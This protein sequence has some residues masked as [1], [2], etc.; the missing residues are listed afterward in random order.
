VIGMKHFLLVFD[1]SQGKLCSLTEF[2][3]R[4]EA[5]QAR[6]DTEKLHRGQPSI[7]VVVLTAHSKAD[8]RHTHARYFEDVRQMASQ[9]LDRVGEARRVAWRGAASKPG[10][11]V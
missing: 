8:L 9:G 5:L 2:E 10:F 4:S 1:R 11:A 6:F 7:E 3:E